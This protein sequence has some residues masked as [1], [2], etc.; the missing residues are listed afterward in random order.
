MLLFCLLLSFLGSGLSSPAADVQPWGTWWEDYQRYLASQG[1]VGVTEGSRLLPDSQQ[2]AIS[3]RC[4]EDKMVVTVQRDLFG[5]G[6]LVKA[7]DLT[8]GP[9]K[10]PPGSQSTNTAVIFQVALQDCGNVL[11]MT[12]DLLIYSTNLTYNPS[13]PRNVPIIRTNAAKVLI[14]CY[15]PRH[16]NVSSNP[17]KP[18]WVPF[19]STISAE[20]RLG[21]S[22][23]L[24]TDD[25][26][27]PRTS[28]I[29]Q[30]GDVFRI[31]ASVDL[32]NHVPMMIYVDS[33]VA[34]QSADVNSSPRYEIIN[35]NGCL[36]DG[37]L[38]DANSAFTSPRS[39]PDEL[40][41]SVDAFRFTGTNSSVIYITC[42]LR[43]V[44]VSQVPDQSNKACSF[45]KASNSWSPLQG[46][47]N[48]CSC[49]DTGNCLVLAGQSRREWT[50]Q[51]YRSIR[52][53]SADSDDSDDEE[54]MDTLGL[55]VVVRTEQSQA[56]AVKE[57]S[58]QLETWEL[59]AL[60]SL[61]LI[62]LTVCIALIVTKLI[63]KRKQYVSA[64]QK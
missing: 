50:N 37:K 5:I 22:L 56:L 54:F 33:C 41:F 19:S 11:Q 8:L 31:Q 64:I 6:K 13:P 43:T 39:Q 14:Q 51:G 53:R 1:A 45:N 3:V 36:V 42:A 58:R 32:A 57:D 29:F 40:Q 23:T 61:G 2:N 48:I 12:S 44:A 60:G 21:F 35:Q 26:S 17:I 15:Y 30:L 38:E 47:T 63:F 9:Q 24:M 18:T 20:E 7:S 27:A 52:K 34:T 25:W 4:G 49:C 28:N 46:P 55:T 59:V 62:L 16:G 10:C